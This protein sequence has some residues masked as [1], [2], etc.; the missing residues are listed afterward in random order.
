MLNR[1][2]LVSIIAIV[3][4]ADMAFGAASLRIG[5]TQNA[6]GTTARAG[7]L[8]TGSVKLAGVTPK[9]S[10]S[11]GTATPT[12]IGRLATSTGGSSVGNSHGRISGHGSGA[13]AAALDELERRVN[14]LADDYGR[15]DGQYDRLSNDVNYAATTATSA[16][17]DINN[18]RTRVD[19]V[20]GK[21]TGLENQGVDTAT[22]NGLIDNKIGNFPTKNE[23]TTQINTASEA[24]MDYADST[25]MTETERQELTRLSS[26]VDTKLSIS[27]AEN[28]YAT[29]TQLNNA[30]VGNESV[31]ADYVQT[32]YANAH[33]ATKPEVNTLSERVDSA[34]T[35]V[36][37]LNAMVSDQASVVAN[38]NNKVTALENAVVALDN[39]VSDKVGVTTYNNLVTE[40]SN[41]LGGK[42]DQS[43]V[44]GLDARITANASTI[45]EHT[46]ALADRVTST[47]LSQAIADVQAGNV[48][49]STINAMI[50][51]ALGE[52]T[53]FV[54]TSTYTGDKETINAQLTQHGNKINA[55][56]NKDDSLTASVNALQLA[57]ESI[58]TALNNK[59]DATYV[60]NKI[61][62]AQLGGG[63]NVDLS[64]Y[65][66]KPETDAVVANATSN[67]IDST[68]ANATFVNKTEFSSYQGTISNALANKVDS[69]TLSSY[70]TVEYVNGK[71]IEATSGIDPDTMAGMIDTAVETALG[72]NYY[73]KDE[74]YNKTEIDATFET[75]QHASD[76]YA[77]KITTN[78]ALTQ[79][80]T[81]VANK[82][83]EQAVDNKITAALSQI[84]TP[85][86]EDIL[87]LQTDVQ[88]LHNKDVQH[89]TAIAGLTTDMVNKANADDVF[90]KEE[91]TNAI[92]TAVAGGVTPEEV[93][94]W[95]REMVNGAAYVSV[96]TYNTDKTD[97][98]SDIS[99]NT[100]AI[101]TL[102]TTVSGHTNSIAT[103]TDKMTSVESGLATAQSDIDDLQDDV[104][105]LEANKITLAQA[106]QNF[107]SKDDDVINKTNIQ[108]LQSGLSAVTTQSNTNKD[109]ITAH[110]T[111][112]SEL[113]SGLST[114]NGKITALETSDAEQN[115]NITSVTNKVNNLESNKIPQLEAADT[116][117][118]NALAQKPSMD[119]VNDAIAQAE[120]GMDQDEVEAIIGHYLEGAS[121]VTTETYTNKVNE[122]DSN[123]TTMNNKLAEKAPLSTVNALTTTVEGNTT[124]IETLSTQKADKSALET[125]QATLTAA[126]ATAEQSAKNYAEEY[127][128]QKV[129]AGVCPNGTVEV[130]TQ[131]QDDGENG[132]KVYIV[133]C[134]QSD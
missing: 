97:I 62:E 120:L 71:V 18:L 114:A 55:L 85:G 102:Q 66:T 87:Q 14:A 88:S 77:N 112:I 9:S 45:A 31:L 11:G 44:N 26:A 52:N 107:I 13:S 54:T 79:L 51:N 127:T 23:V 65:Y 29:K 34:A 109:D 80:S 40:V 4:C 17:T 92:N 15:L 103:L 47:Q 118:S 131:D 91:T 27:D 74:V 89:D 125:A 113:Q 100:S 86:Q 39:A 110:S 130:V 59:V 134:V 49:E 19:T 73:N 8:R 24:L 25:G 108:A 61:N 50:Q 69:S 116:Q 37:S 129:A 111:A 104:T 105:S 121:F 32:T 64:N 123:L 53:T 90:T 48:D 117:L 133:N 124:N 46:N 6:T 57:N 126:I 22:I 30:I 56:E 35:S 12:T 7:T 115:T 122:I 101:A 28:T 128:N 94:E 95:V 21:I 58:T 33:F 132:G 93:Q 81:A 41:A 1:K 76:T 60:T 82:L 5:G 67:K 20:E 42:A 2:T 83:D 36:N 72:N 98:Q 16:N 78:N 84:G 96:D 119:D 75:Q 68:T 63:G 99:E 106:N 70:A 3:C 10:V 43:V 38:A